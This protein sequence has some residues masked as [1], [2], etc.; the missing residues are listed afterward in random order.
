MKTI[1]VFDCW[2]P[3][4]KYIRDLSTDFGVRLIFIHTGSLHLGAPA[5]EH[6]SFLKD[7]DTPSWVFDFKDFGY[8]FSTLFSKTKPDAI[9]VLS[10]HHIESRTA[11]VFAHHMGLESFFIPHGIFVLNSASIVKRPQLSFRDYLKYIWIKIPRAVFYTRFF[12]QFHD[13]MVRNNFKKWNMYNI[14]QVL[15]CLLFK[16]DTWQHRPN[17]VVQSYYNNII[18]NIIIYDNDI[19]NYYIKNY[20]LMV[21]EAQF[22]MS[23]TLDGGKL[24]RQMKSGLIGTGENAATKVAYFISTPYTEYFIE[25][26]TGTY[27]DII[28]NIKFAVNAAGFERFVYRPHPGEPTEFAEHICAEVGADI[29]RRS[30]LM[31]IVES[32]VICS[33]SSSLL[34]CAILLGKP[35]VTW[36]SRRLVFDCPY[37]EPLISYP[38]IAIDADLECDETAISA[39]RTSQNDPVS[40]NMTDLLDPL[41]DL[42][43]LVSERNLLQHTDDEVFDRA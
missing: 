37:Y 5:N 34:Y 13:Q 32:S 24:G 23:G 21:G 1:L 18:D 36:S 41:S 20:G 30:D 4:Y 40:S 39:L 16:F 8:C 19:K 27:V 17:W 29:D 38:R 14:L 33:T 31:G 22:Y 11:L 43:R 15:S 12:L 25:P 9:L 6:K 2:L 42:V 26:N 28:R 3:G 35:I 10:L 7:P